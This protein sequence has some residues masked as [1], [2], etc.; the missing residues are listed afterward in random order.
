VATAAL[1][2]PGV[3]LT[4]D[5]IRPFVVVWR[6][7]S[8]LALHAAQA[9]LPELDLET[10]GVFPRG[11]TTEY[12]RDAANDLNPVTRAL[13]I[14]SVDSMLI[15]RDPTDRWACVDRM[16]QWIAAYKVV[17]DLASRHFEWGI[18]AVAFVDATRACFPRRDEDLK[19]LGG[20]VGESLAP[21]ERACLERCVA[22]VLASLPAPERASA[23]GALYEHAAA[24]YSEDLPNKRLERT[25]AGEHDLGGGRSR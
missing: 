15:T 12:A 18:S 16:L 23:L 13:G 9:V 20:R 19:V 4:E 14:A 22:T 7:D 10:A 8:T 6:A 21:G 17:E 2:T 25:S 24:F 1:L 3:A 11:W 5:A